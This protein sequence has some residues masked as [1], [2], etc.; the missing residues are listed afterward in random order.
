[1]TLCRNPLKWEYFRDLSWVLYLVYVNV[2]LTLFHTLSCKPRLFADN[3][4]LVITGPA[5]FDL[6]KQCK[7][8]LQKLCSC[9]YANKLQVNPTK[10]VLLV[11]SPKQITLNLI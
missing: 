8:E 2:F 5:T 1:M 10:S 4:C 7:L 3:T 11:S 9:Y 6:E